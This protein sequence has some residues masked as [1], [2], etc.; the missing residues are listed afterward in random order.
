M[1]SPCESPPTPPLVA[2][3]N[4][5]D[6]TSLP[7]L[8]AGEGFRD[9]LFFLLLELVGG[10]EGTRKC[11]SLVSVPPRWELKAEIAELCDKEPEDVGK[12]HGQRA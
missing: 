4:P 11:S 10:G 5:L 7:S 12:V 6:L 2:G 3:T 9:F 8:D 1:P